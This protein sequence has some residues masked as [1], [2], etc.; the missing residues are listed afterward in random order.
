MRSFDYLSVLISIVLGLGITNLLTGL[1]ALVRH[2]DRVI[3][4]WPLPVWMVT[5]F[6]IHVQTWWALFGLRGT[7][8]W[9]FAS[10]LVVLL[11]PVALFVMTA[12]IVPDVAGVARIDLRTAFFRETRGFFGALFLALLASLAKNLI[13][14]GT[15][16]EGRN[17]AAHIVFIA[18]ALVGGV[19]R[20]PRIH[21][22]LA[23]LGLILLACYIALLFT[24]LS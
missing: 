22:T 15:F 13:L 8:Q 24:T 12:L 21:A 4:Y 3:A 2:R 17:L 19:S 18:I 9:S 20:S 14:S 11:Q 10:F 16:P 5:V 23:P 6:L 7:E 1:A